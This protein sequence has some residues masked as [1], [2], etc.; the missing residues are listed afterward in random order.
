M[1]VQRHMEQVRGVK[2]LGVLHLLGQPNLI[3]EVDRQEWPGMA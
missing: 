1:Q 2:D 3:I